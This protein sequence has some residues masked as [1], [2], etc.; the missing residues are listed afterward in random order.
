[1][2]TQAW[3]NEHGSGNQSPSECDLI[4]KGGIASGIVYPKAILTL[5]E[6]FRFRCIGGTSAGAMAAAAAAAAEYGRGVS[7]KD[8]AS[9][10]TACGFERLEHE[11]TWLANADDKNLLNLF[12]PSRRTRPLF[13][14][15]LTLNRE[16]A[17]LLRGS[18][19]DALRRVGD[20]L[21]VQTPSS[22]QWGARQGALS[23]GLAIGGAAMLA[24]VLLGA[25]LCVVL[26]VAGR[27][28][29][30]NPSS[31]TIWASRATSAAL[32]A[33]VVWFTLSMVS[34]RG[35]RMLRWLMVRTGG[36]SSGES[37]MSQRGRIALA[38]LVTAVTSV[39]F[40][41]MLGG[42]TEANAPNWVAAI[43]AV[44]LASG[45]LF[46][47]GGLWLGRRVGAALGA[48]VFSVVELAQILFKVVPDENKFGLCTGSTE[49]PERSDPKV[50]TDWLSATVNKLAGRAADD[51]P[52]TFGDLRERTIN[53]RT[54]PVIFKVVTT[55][56][57]EAQ[58]YVFPM[59]PEG[60]D[61]D[62]IGAGTVDAFLFNEAE[63]RTL[64]PGRIV[65][66]LLQNPGDIRSLRPPDGYSILPSG[67]RLPIVVAARLSLSLPL[68]LSAIPLY[69][70]QVSAMSE[71]RAPADPDTQGDARQLSRD[72][73][74][75]CWFSDGGIASNFPIH[76]FDAWLPLRPTFGIRLTPRPDKL[77]TSQIEKLGN[78]K[79][80]PRN[81]SAST[82]APVATPSMVQFT[83][84]QAQGIED[85]FLPRAAEPV[86]PVWSEITSLGDFVGKVWH[87]AQN[88]RD[89]TQS[90]LP[91]YR[92][93]IVQVHLATDEGG[94]NLDMS[95]TI[96]EG[97][98][99]KGYRAAK[100]LIA[101]GGH[102]IVPPRDERFR[103]HQWVRLRVLMT[104]FEREI[105]RI[106]SNFG[107]IW[108]PQEPG[109]KPKTPE[110]LEELY[111]FIAGTYTWL[112]EQQLLHEWY[113]P[114]SLEW[115]TEMS[116][117]LRL[118][119]CFMEGWRRADLAAA[120][121]AGWPPLFGNP[122]SP[123]PPPVMR[124][125]PTL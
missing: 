106:E 86:P 68:V 58:P 78:R 104:Q 20:I 22:H 84:T 87:T 25:V 101:F 11:R 83:E 56:L 18:P 90:M 46:A 79:I 117:R 109:W 35:W 88:F 121:G 40:W 115:T 16:A 118:L 9:G 67:D 59:Y 3:Q 17:N 32:C 107:A 82:S 15:G 80:Q 89:N 36:R 93:R 122:R 19:L 24:G 108:R 61:A 57:S 69:T 34:A 13:E 27:V 105:Q 23:A 55:N 123:Q 7:F 76:M 2:D 14:T 81:L 66:H 62:D 75:K 73:L 74:K 124:V 6:T 95:N 96:I 65:D 28:A 64:F 1:M 54:E 70:V 37:P 103:E 91:S 52:L 29:Q 100:E 42:L 53:G 77:S 110:D 113:A 26:A 125:T 85:V 47:A 4:M 49:D 45:L 51:R 48:V 71:D 120:P 8:I 92:E 102:G 33:L 43:T 99:E 5:A 39:L 30:Q 50:L 60:R 38:A 21:Q 94:M 72:Q 31:V 97:M 10:D 112:A 116:K 41:L 98:E 12:R 63:F 114:E 111:E 44:V 119:L